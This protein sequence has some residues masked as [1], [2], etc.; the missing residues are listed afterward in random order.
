MSDTVDEPDEFSYR[1][2]HAAN[3]EIMRCLSQLEWADRMRRLM[4]LLAAEL[5]R[6]GVDFSRA[7]E[8]P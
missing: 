3:V 2:S 4:P 5:V 1:T 7:G 6:M 8:R